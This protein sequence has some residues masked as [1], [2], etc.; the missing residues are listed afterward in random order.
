MTAKDYT[1]PQATADR[2]IA[3]FGATG[4]I[5]RTTTSGP[6]HDPTITE[7]DYAAIIVTPGYTLTNRDGTLIQAGDKVG[8]IAMKDLAVTPTMAD[9]VVIESK[10]YSFVDLQPLRPAGTT[11]LYEF[12]ARA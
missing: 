5:R 3:R 10:A 8:L 6:A 2:L 9:K 1:A 11:V 7:T 12:V 4:A